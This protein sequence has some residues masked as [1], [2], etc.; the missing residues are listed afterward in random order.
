V[1]LKGDDTIPPNDKNVLNTIAA[2]AAARLTELAG[3]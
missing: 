3:E 1:E 2:E